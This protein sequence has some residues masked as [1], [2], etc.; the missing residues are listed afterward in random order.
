M[1][2]MGYTPAS[3]RR[4]RPRKALDGIRSHNIALLHLR[5]SSSIST[6]VL[7]DVQR[8]L[9]ERNLNLIFSHGVGIDAVPQAVRCGN[10]DGILGYGEF[11]EG[12]DTAGI[13]KIPAVWMMSRQ[14]AGTADAW[15]DRVKPDHQ[16]IGRLAANYLLERGHRHVAYFN[17]APLA[18]VYEERGLAFQAT[19]RG[20]AE[21]IVLLSAHNN[22]E[23]PELAG[24]ERA[25]EQFVEQWLG[26]SPRPTGVFVPV[27]RVTLRVYRHLL[28]HGVQPGADVE[29]VSCDKEEEL[30]SLMHPA[31]QSID[32][33]RRA[34]ARLAVER[35]LWRMRHGASAP[36]I[37]IA[38]AP[39]L[40][41]PECQES[42]DANR[43][44]G[45][46]FVS[47]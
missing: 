39:M 20:R 10:V 7:A 19:C 40:A 47:P 21:S 8:M 26:T 14:N 45:T 2:R 4:G 38:V 11:P 30:L 15:G 46:S 13:R 29:I 33:N 22:H 1:T 9:A 23:L 25:A 18:G 28:Q 43:L 6:S 35:L 17:P 27:D 31:P 5:Q 41:L 12:A 34:I 24:M 36:A 44:M 32:L 42:H 16:A 3:A 37:T